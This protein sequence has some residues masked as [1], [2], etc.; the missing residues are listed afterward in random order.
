MFDGTVMVPLFRG[1]CHFVFSPIRFDR[2][3]IDSL[4]AFNYKVN[5]FSPPTKVG[6]SVWLALKEKVNKQDDRVNN[7]NHGCDSHQIQMC[8][9]KM[10]LPHEHII[11]FFDISCNLQNT[12]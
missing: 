11:T 6:L 9:K 3:V 8:I 10:Q 4:I 5:D 2:A 12:T 1:L 7:S